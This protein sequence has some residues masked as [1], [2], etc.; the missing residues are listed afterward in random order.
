MNIL[1][2][3]RIGSLLMALMNKLKTTAQGESTMKSG[4]K[5]SEFWVAILSSV[6]GIMVVLGWITPEQ[7]GQLSEAITQAIGGLISI[8]ATIA[9]IFSRAKVKTEEKKKE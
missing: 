2:I 7:Q 9:Y 6:I 8:I 1:H 3:M 4:W 5:T